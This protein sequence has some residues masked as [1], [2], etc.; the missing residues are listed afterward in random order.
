[1]SNINRGYSINFV[2]NTITITEKFQKEAGIKGTPARKEM[3]ALR[4]DFPDMEIVRRAPKKASKKARTKY[5][6]ME[7]YIALLDDAPKYQA[8]FEMVK[9]HSLTQSSPASF[10]KKWFFATFP[11]FGKQI[12]FDENGDIT[13]TIDD[14]AGQR[15]ID[16]A[17]SE[18]A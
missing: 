1:M 16:E 8:R 2:A 14:T 7:K 10:T 15:V 4:R 18:A 13:I 5:V 3:K 12:K 6:H 11:D 9:L 17:L